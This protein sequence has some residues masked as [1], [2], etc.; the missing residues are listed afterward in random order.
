MIGRLFGRTAKPSGDHY[1]SFTEL[2]RREREGRDYIRTILDRRSPIAIVAPHGG[3]LEAGTSEVATAIAG[4]D[5]SLYVFEGIKLKGNESLHVTSIH[6]D[7]PSCLDL[8]SRTRMAVAIHGFS[9]T[10][11]GIRIG[12]L[13]ADLKA[14]VIPALID[15]GFIPLEDDEVFTGLDPAN[16]CN[17]TATGVGLQLELSRGL[18]AAMFSGLERSERAYTTPVFRRFVTAIRGALLATRPA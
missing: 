12:G 18:R 14:A 6:F 5:M 10:D 16:I 8:L 13:D 3:G 11:M 7:D 9:G 4:R 2:A 17:R 1:A 15:A